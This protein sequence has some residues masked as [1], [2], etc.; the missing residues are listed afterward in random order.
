MSLSILIPAKNEKDNLP[1]VLDKIIS[2]L[3]F[4]LDYEIVVIKADND[5]SDRNLNIKEFNNLKIIQQKTPGYGAALKEG[6]TTATKKYLCIF[7][8]DGSFDVKDIKKL[9]DK[10]NDG[11]DF[12]YCSRYRKDAGSEDDSII[13]FIGNKFF[14]FIGN[15]FFKIKISDI[16]FTYFLADTKK[17][18][19]LNL[20]SNDF[21]ICVEIPIK[22]HMN[23]FNYTEISSYEYKRMYGK[24]NVNEFKDGFLI[25]IKLIK[26]Y[27]KKNDG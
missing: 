9:Y 10:A 22:M 4:G 3:N 15:F 21:G 16:L 8:A 19:T 12:V 7:N 18:Q 13:T 14:S 20:L 6:F 23:N 27:I 25:L 17:I 24:K 26:L 2:F 1:I 5:D 11:N